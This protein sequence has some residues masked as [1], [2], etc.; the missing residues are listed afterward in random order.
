MA[1]SSYYYKR[2]VVD[3]PPQDL[4]GWKYGVDNSKT[5][6]DLHKGQKA[7]VLKSPVAI[8]MLALS[9]FLLFWFIYSFVHATI[10]EGNVYVIVKFLPSFFVLAVCI[11]IVFLTVFGV[12][13]KFVRWTLKNKMTG[14]AAHDIHIL[15]AQVEAADANVGRE[16]A[17]NVYE[18]YIEVVNSGTRRVLDRSVLRNVI[19]KKHG[20]YCSIRFISLRGEPVY[21]DAKIP[22][23]DI[24][25]LKEIFGGICTVEKARRIKTS[26]IKDDVYVEPHYERGDFSFDGGKV[27]GIVMGFICAAV[28]GVVIALHYC[29]NEK[30]PE[31][32]GMFFIAGGVLVITTVFAEFA[33]VK[34]FIIPFLFGA[35]LT[36]FPFMLIFSVAQTEGTAVTLPTFHEFLC[37]FSPLNG[38]MFFLA[39]IGLML[40]IYSVVRLIK[41]L[42]YR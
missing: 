31:F 24:H 30:I 3:D 17:L 33:V 22:T 36:G 18:D 21:A 16:N 15:Q 23:A 42:R 5:Q 2:F 6:Y 38:G 34:V 8:Y 4:G 12:W 27:A 28:G 19:I 11:A 9:A 26:R 13:G 35:I 7:A 29:V 14:G 20:R 1:K 41:Y 37:S 40:I 32:L 25:V 10:T 39:G